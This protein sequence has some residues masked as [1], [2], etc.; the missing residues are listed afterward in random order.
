M[1]VANLIFLIGGFIHAAFYGFCSYHI[2]T[3]PHADRK[4]RRFYKRSLV[5]KIHSFVVNFSGVAI[6]WI[7][8][9]LLFRD[10]TSSWST[11]I[12]IEAIKLGHGFI[13]VF[14]LLGLWGILPNAIWGLSNTFKIMLDK[15]LSL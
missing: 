10:L 15:L 4:Y 13:F 12:D 14:C 8:A 7:C 2:F 9:Y 6:G 3:F 1:R 11:T 5:M